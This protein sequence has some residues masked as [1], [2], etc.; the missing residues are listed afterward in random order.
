MG[1]TIPATGA[2]SFSAIRNFFVTTTGQTS[3]TFGMTPT[4]EIKLSQF[5]N[6]ASKGVVYRN[7]E[8]SLSNIYSDR[9]DKTISI[10]S[11]RGITVANRQVKIRVRGNT[12]NESVRIQCFP[13]SGTTALGDT[14]TIT[15]SSTATTYTLCTVTQTGTTKEPQYIRLEYFNDG[16]SNDVFVEFISYDGVEAMW[17]TR[18][19]DLTSYYANNDSRRNTLVAG[20]F[21]WG[22]VYRIKFCALT[23]YVSSPG[24]V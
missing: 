14:N 11:I 9:N 8:Q 5:K 13:L 7:G 22:G 18:I 3:G 17:P 1:G 15:L 19:E 4:G 12:G 6:L 2:V 23:G 10:N 24:Y 20:T 16:G 21:A